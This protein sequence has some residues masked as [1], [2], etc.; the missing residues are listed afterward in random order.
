MK[1]SLLASLEN[2]MSK[3]IEESCEEDDW[4]DFYVHE[5]LATQMAKA[6]AIVIDASFDGQCE[7][8]SQES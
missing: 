4:P 5:D 2:A 7:K 6:A 1:I 8:E 3:W